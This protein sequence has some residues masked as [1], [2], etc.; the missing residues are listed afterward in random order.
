MITSGELQLLISEDGVSGVTSNRQFVEKAIAES[1]DYD[2]RIRDTHTETDGEQRDLRITH[3]G[4]ISGR[5]RTFYT[6]P[7]SLQMG[8]M[9]C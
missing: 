8:G 1:H 5:R 3:R 2:E 4:T 9:L 7:T 6:R